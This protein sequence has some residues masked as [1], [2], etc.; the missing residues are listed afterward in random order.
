MTATIHELPTPSNDVE[1]ALLTAFM[2]AK[3]ADR[4]EAAATVD[5]R[6]FESGR[7]RTIWEALT[8]LH[9]ADQPVEAPV[10]LDDLERRGH[11]DAAGGYVYISDVLSAGFD[12]ASVVE[13]ARR[14]VSRAQR[15]HAAVEAGHLAHALQDPSVDVAEQ[16]Y[17][18]VE[19]LLATVNEG[20]GGVIRIRDLADEIRK[21][22]DEGPFEGYRCGVDSVD[23]YYR[24][25]AGQLSVVTGTPSAGKSTWLAW[26]LVQMAAK[27]QWRVAV[28]TPESRPYPKWSGKLIEAAAGKPLRS[29][30]NDELERALRWCD[31]HFE[32]INDMK[33]A[34]LRGILANARLVHERRPLNGLVIDPWNWVETSR[35]PGM[36]ATEYIGLAL[37][38]VTRFAIRHNLHAWVVAHPTK[39][40]K[41]EAGEMAGSY[42]VPGPYDISDSANWFNKAWWCL[43]VWRDHLMPQFGEQDYNE[44]R[45]PHNVDVHVQKARDDDQGRPGVAQLRYLPG[46]RRY[47]PLVAHGMGRSM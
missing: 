18:T 7:H 27:H 15:R 39:M 24:P 44:N 16:V 29:L 12:G 36:N 31:E 23:R 34:T 10:V 8:R 43:S 1:A 6:H 17:E 40:R 19:R 20:E 47:G 26:Y 5:P 13:Y 41:V 37:N 25:D 4:S 38:E 30:S 28:F 11:L 3:P 32:I 46:S 45:D 2:W 14:V 9:R 21:L 35:P 42:I 33:D 22:R